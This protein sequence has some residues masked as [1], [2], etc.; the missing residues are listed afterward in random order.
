MR[1]RPSTPVVGRITPPPFDTNAKNIEEAWKSISKRLSPRT[2]R[3]QRTALKHMW[4]M[5]IGWTIFQLESRMTS[6][7]SAD[8]FERLVDDLSEELDMQ[9]I[10]QRFRG[11]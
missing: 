10:T 11:L 9:F 4:F 6:D 3:Q 7:G 5:G 8:W 2:T 1:K